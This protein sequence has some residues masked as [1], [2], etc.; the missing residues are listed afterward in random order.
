MAAQL[1]QVDSDAA[2]ICLRLSTDELAADLVHCLRLAFDD[3]YRP[4]SLRKQAAGGCTGQAAA[5]DD[6][7]QRHFSRSMQ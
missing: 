7:R 3:H 6:D 4:P 2:E 1:P 5:G